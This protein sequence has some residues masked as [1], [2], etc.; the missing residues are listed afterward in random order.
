MLALSEQEKSYL[1]KFIDDFITIN[2]KRY[3]VKVQREPNMEILMERLAKLVGINSAHYEMATYNNTSYDL[4][5]DLNG[6]G[7]FTLGSDISLDA[8]LY[9]EESDIS[10]K[11]LYTIWSELEKK[12]PQS[13]ENLMK[14]I[15][16]MYI[17]DIFLLIHD[18]ERR[19]WGILSNED[20]DNLYLFDNESAFNNWYSTAE[21]ST[22][23]KVNKYESVTTG[24]SR[25]RT[26]IEMNMEYLEYFMN[27]SSEEYVE[28][29]Y[30]IYNV[31]TPEIL[32]DTILSVEKEYGSFKDTKRI[33]EL[34]KENYQAIGSIINKRGYHVNNKR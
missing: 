14:Q 8:K 33:I 13:I 10:Y 28:I 20:G 2:D 4:S 15:I 31:L 26:A 5:E 16:T 30:K 12:Y 1:Y 7:L 6:L 9:K 29:V 3:Y 17:F 11:S 25:K 24:K 32:I 18:R 22:Y 23:E 27:T 19:N 34:Y 21:I